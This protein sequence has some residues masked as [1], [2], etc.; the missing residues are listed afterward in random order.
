MKQIIKTDQA[1]APVG[2][3]NQ[4]IIANGILYGSIC[5]RLVLELCF[6]LR[7]CFR[8]RCLL[9]LLFLSL[10]PR[11]QT[12]VLTLGTISAIHFQT[13]LAKE[14]EYVCA[15]V[16]VSVCECECECQYAARHNRRY[17]WAFSVV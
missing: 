2:P 1:P 10:L 3:Y 13:C 14:C 15:D 17:L 4:A 9:D 12:Y 7:C 8:C 6:F 11:S 5:L 16:C